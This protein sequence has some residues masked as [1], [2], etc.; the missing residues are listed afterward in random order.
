MLVFSNLA[1]M[2]KA[3]WGLI[4]E[5]KE[6]WVCVLCNKYKCGSDI[7][8]QVRLRNGCSNF[9]KGVRRVWPMV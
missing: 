9:W 6:L 3:G 2:A 4:H 5:E 8:L 1:F 7:I